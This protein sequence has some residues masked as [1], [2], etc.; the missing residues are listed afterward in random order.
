MADQAQMLN[1]DDENSDYDT[2]DTEY[3]CGDDVASE[4]QWISSDWRAHQLREYKA[5]LKKREQRHKHQI[6]VMEEV[7]TE[8]NWI[9]ADISSSI[10]SAIETSVR[11][12]EELHRVQL[13]RLGQS[14]EKAASIESGILGLS[15][16]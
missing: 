7:S 2:D 4:L 12:R 5:G 10:R 15:V 13:I 1:G 16:I 6:I 14:T 8:L 11:N 9:A 3:D